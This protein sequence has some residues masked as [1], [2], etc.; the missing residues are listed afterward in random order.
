[1][2]SWNR[3][4]SLR[5]FFRRRVLTVQI[6]ALRT[7]REQILPLSELFTQAIA[8]GLDCAV[9][10]LDNGLVQQ[11][12]L[13]HVWPGNIRELKSAA[14][15]LVL[16]L[17]SQGND[18]V[19]VCDADGGLKT[20]LRA[21]DKM[22]IADTLKHHKH[23]LEVVVWGGSQFPVHV[24]SPRERARPDLP[25]GGRCFCNAETLAVSKP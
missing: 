10:V 3:V 19:L 12:L 13:S 23:S 8:R 24:V 11:L 17:P 5:S 6:P 18:L 25:W 16:G 14:K 7:R 22:L 9:P 2:D 21:I 4:V 20:Q 15:R 1:M